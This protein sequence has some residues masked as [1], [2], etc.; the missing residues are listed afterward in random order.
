MN[1]N[2]T[3]AFYKDF[4]SFYDKHLKVIRDL[5]WS[6]QLFDVKATLCKH[7]ITQNFNPP[8]IHSSSTQSIG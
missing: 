8:Q 3:I 2:L 4:V 6:D 1:D 7:S 5:D